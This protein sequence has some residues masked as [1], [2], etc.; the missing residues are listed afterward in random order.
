MFCPPSFVAELLFMVV[1][2]LICLPIKAIDKHF[3]LFAKFVD[4]HTNSITHLYQ[5]SK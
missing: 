4:R 1:S 5:K 3:R 2:Q